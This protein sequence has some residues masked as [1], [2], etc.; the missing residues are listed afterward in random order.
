RAP[1]TP[2]AIIQWGAR[3][4]QRVLTTTL[5]RADD[6]ARAAGLANPA[7]IIIGEVVALRDRLSWFEK[8]PLFGRRILVP[9]PAHQAAG[10]AK[11]IR[12]CGAEPVV[13]PLIEIDDPPDLEALTAAVRA[14]EEYDWVLFTSANGVERF[15]A[16]V[17]RQRKDAR[18]F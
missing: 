6:Q 12:E 5:E 2:V 10:T 17:Y 18:V 1:E 14:A 4:N 11:L 13:M 16:E 3:P 9:T 8:Q 15:M 7:V